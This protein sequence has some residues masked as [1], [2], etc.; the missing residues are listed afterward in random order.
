MDKSCAN[1][2][3]LKKIMNFIQLPL[4]YFSLTLSGFISSSSS[5]ASIILLPFLIQLTPHHRYPLLSFQILS[6][7]S[8][9]PP[10]L[11]TFILLPPSVSLPPPGPRNVAAALHSNEN[12]TEAVTTRTRSFSTD[13]LNTL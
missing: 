3:M 10:Q 12:R 4:S 6:R 8:C 11:A 13:C 1:I 7:H 5:S 9:L 2:G